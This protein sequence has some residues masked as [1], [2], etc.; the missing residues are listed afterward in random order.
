MGLQPSFVPALKI[1]ITVSRSTI[2]VA[3]YHL[4]NLSDFDA[5]LHDPKIFKMSGAVSAVTGG[6]S[7]LNPFSSSKKEADGDDTGD[8]IE[9][10]SIGGGGHASRKSTVPKGQLRVSKALKA[11][12][13]H[14]GA[15]SD[16]DAEGEPNKLS[17]ALKSLLEKH[18]VICPKELTDRSHPLS[19]YFISSSHNTYLMAHQLYGKADAVAYEVAL[20]TGSRCVEID[21]WDDDE[22]KEEPKVTHGFTLASHI[23]FR[24][25]CETLAHIVDK[26]AKEAEGSDWRAA[27]IM[28]SLENHCSAQGQQRLA[29]I[30]KEVLGD[31]LLS[32]QVRDEGTAEQEG[33]GKPVTL[34]ELGSK[35]VVIVEFYF[36]DQKAEYSSD[37]EEEAQ[38]SEDK[39]KYDKQKKENPKAE[40]II[41]ELAELGVYAQSVK[42]I[43]KSWIEGELKNGPHD[44]L[45]NVSESGLASLM[46]TSSANIGKH[47]SKHLMRVYPKGTRI[48][49]A[50][51]HP[52]P[53]WG[54]GAQI[55]ALNWQTFGAALQLNEALFAGSDGYVLKPAALRPGGSGKMDS[56]KKKKLRL[57][58]E[59]AT[60]IQVPEDR[61]D[62]IVPYVSC[63]L[64]HPDDLKDEPPKRKTSPYKPHKLGVLHKGANPPPTNP[65]WNETLE[66]EYEDNDLTFLRLLIK[67]DDKF[68][69]NPVLVVAS[70]RLMYTSP[71]WCFIRML[72]LKGRETKCTLLVKFEM[73]DA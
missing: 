63:T 13:A 70:V 42:P 4:I 30:M 73:V 69:S 15:I 55:C 27:P 35:I 49:S 50:N 32:K 64:H 39:K 37:E 61:S 7:K 17:P 56:G 59:G 51:L 3:Q 72:D 5:H 36:P 48:S 24:S 9:A 14:E 46:G 20:G 57:R 18:H 67:S 11:V 66:W 43:D 12:L 60:D 23:S 47:N 34:E 26:E 28:I 21:A 16:K 45:I 6:L 38:K 1:E 52:V 71:D 54:I 10:D 65:I 33:T 53:F 58:V 29:A 68:A 19:E 40:K 22:N 8:V 2:E 31:R 25:V 62:K 41:P 44:H